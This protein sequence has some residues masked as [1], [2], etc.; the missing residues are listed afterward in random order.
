MLR[1]YWTKISIFERT[2]VIEAMVEIM[3][4]TKL[5][6]QGRFLAHIIV[7]AIVIVF[8]KVACNAALAFNLSTTKN[9]DLFCAGILALLFA[10]IHSGISEYKSENKIVRPFDG[11]IVHS[12]YYHI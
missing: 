4:L 8:Y 11:I 10:M 5:Q 7:D 9:F 2:W 12:E 6:V 1:S 3:Y